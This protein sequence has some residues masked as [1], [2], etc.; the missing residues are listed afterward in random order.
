MAEKIFLSVSI[1]GKQLTSIRSL[2]VSQGIFEHHTFEVVIPGGSVEAD[3]AKP[4]KVFDTVADWIGKP[5]I[6][7]WETGSFKTERDNTEAS[8]FHGIVMNVSVSGQSKEFMSVTITGKSPTIL[9]D[10]VPNSETYANVGLMDMYKKVIVSAPVPEL[11]AED[12]LA[13]KGKL[14]FNTQYNETDWNFMCRMMHENGEWFYYDGEKINLGTAKAKTV[15]MQPQH[16]DSLDFSFSVCR[17]VGPLRAWDYLKNAE[18][19]IKPADPKHTD[20]HAKT[21][22]KTSDNLYPS[23]K[24]DHRAFPSFPDGD[25]HHSKKDLLAERLDK[26]RQGKGNDVFTLIGSSDVGDVQLGSVIKLDGFGHGGEYIVTRVTHTCNGPDN[27]QNYFQAVPTNAGIPSSVGVMHP[28]IES[29][30]AK[31]TDNKDPKKL[32]RVRVKFDWGSQPTPWLRIV[33]PHAGKNRGFYFVPE[34]GDEVMVGFEMGHEAFPYVMGS[35]YNGK[36]AQEGKYEDKDKLK[37][38]RT[39]SGNEILFDDNGRLVFSNA[40]NSIELSCKDKGILTIMTKGDMILKADKNIS[41]E[42]GENLT[43]KAGKDMKVEAVMKHETKS[44]QDMKVESSMKYELKS[45]LDMAIKAGMNAKVE[46]A[47]NLQA[48][49][50]LNAELSGSVQL[51]VS[52]G[53]TAELS[54]G[55]MTTVK[56]GLVKIN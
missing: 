8:V 23:R 11:S 33:W 31:V 53:A 9:L 46:A 18:L 28:R 41:I 25:E 10:G 51:K 50:G 1:A 19:E 29:S 14:P 56:G 48:K 44:G 5:I 39:I 49:A 24:E 12:K 34:I 13:F 45:G 35:L 40:E 21:I 47:M 2:S 20:K 4:E 16:L 3:P 22:Q 17:P 42:S 15:K 6:I 55:A 52:G 43:I 27:Y 38:I 54:G 30:T 37:V 36:N 7:D 32:G 26:S